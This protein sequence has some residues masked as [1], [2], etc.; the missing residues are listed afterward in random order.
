MWSPF[1]YKY[2]KCHSLPTNSH[3]NELGKSLSMSWDSIEK[4]VSSYG[5][6]NA[7]N[8]KF[9]HI[10]HFSLY[11]VLWT[12][13]L[14]FACWWN[15]SWAPQADKCCPDLDFVCAI[16]QGE[17]IAVF[18]NSWGLKWTQCSTQK[19]WLM[20]PMHTNELISQSIH[21]NC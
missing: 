21:C 14:S 9:N 15:V 19:L 13:I 2:I 5:S 16:F 4:Q 6:P 11:R 17:L 3:H 20:N 1:V 10:A 18:H 7:W 8:R 12:Y